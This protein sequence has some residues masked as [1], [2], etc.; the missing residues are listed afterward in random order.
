MRN[1]TQIVVGVSSDETTLGL[2]SE[3]TPG[4][5][6]PIKSMIEM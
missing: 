4:T 2:E 3:E 6:F 5:E 1:A